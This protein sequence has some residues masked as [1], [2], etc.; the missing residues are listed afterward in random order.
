[1]TSTAGQS[2]ACMGVIKNA[3][4]KVLRAFCR[5]EEDQNFE[6]FADVEE[7]MVDLGCNEDHAAGLYDLFLGSDAHLR[8]A[9]NHVIHLVFFM[10]SLRIGAAGRQNVDPG[11]ESWNPQ[12]FL[13][14]LSGLGA[15]GRDR[16]K[17]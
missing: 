3:I 8:V 2:S 4:A 10:R 11:A 12:E 16:G 14:E 7:A 17:I 6:F 15:L 13:I 5:G 9:P 1:M